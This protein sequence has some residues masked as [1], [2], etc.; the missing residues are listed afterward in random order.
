M[1]VSHLLYYF[2][3]KDALLEEMYSAFSSSVLSNIGSTQNLPTE[4]RCRLFADN[5]FLESV[6]PSSDQTIIFE[7]LAYAAHNPRFRR[8]QEKHT[9]TTMAYLVN[10]LDQAPQTAGLSAEDA[11]AVICAIWF[12][13]LVVSYMYKPMNPPRLRTLFKRILLHMAGVEDHQSETSTATSGVA[14]KRSDR[15]GAGS[16]QKDLDQSAAI[17]LVSPTAEPAE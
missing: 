5:M 8:S 16:A 17:S 1:S 7:M 11:A 2:P 12:G 15:K 6:I 13:F 3:S 9:R 10:L 14:K 4:E